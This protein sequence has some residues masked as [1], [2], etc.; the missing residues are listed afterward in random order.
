MGMSGLCY[1][2]ETV[3]MTALCIYLNLNPQ[4]V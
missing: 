3:A 2:L 4:M 1:D